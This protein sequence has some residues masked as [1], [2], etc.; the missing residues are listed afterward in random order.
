M[1]FTVLRGMCFR[2]R[3]GEGKVIVL[4]IAKRGHRTCPRFFYKIILSF[5]GLDL[6]NITTIINGY[7]VNNPFLMTISNRIR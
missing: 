5:W 4:A 3:S 2:K 1:K 7:N 6:I